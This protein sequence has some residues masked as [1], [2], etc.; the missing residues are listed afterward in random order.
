LGGAEA[1]APVA[2]DA[3]GFGVEGDGAEGGGVGGVGEEV[4]GEAVDPGLGDGPVFVERDL[5]EELDGHGGA[6]E[7]DARTE[8]VLAGQEAALG[9]GAAGSAAGGEGAADVFA[10]CVELGKLGNGEGS[11]A[12]GGALGGEGKEVGLQALLAVGEG[13]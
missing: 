6:V 7:G 3:E 9:I 5:E 8:L 11:G 1:G 4:G 10:A 2:D 13:D 12:G